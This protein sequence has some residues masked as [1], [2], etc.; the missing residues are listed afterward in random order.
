MPPP[1]EIADSLE[2]MT[3]DCDLI[4]L[5]H[6]YKLQPDV[7][8]VDDRTL[9]AQ[10]T[11]QVTRVLYGTFGADSLSFYWKADRVTPMDN[12]PQLYFLRRAANR[13]GEHHPAPWALRNSVLP[14]ASSQGLAT[15]TGGLAR[16]ADE[17][18]SVIESESAI[19]TANG[20]LIHIN[21][22]PDNFSRTKPYRRI[23]LIA[24][25]ERAR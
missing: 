16:T 12:R 24:L 15:A 10:A 25:R 3:W 4:V 2:W 17:I 19:R 8:A 11:I 6:P 22:G 1:I 14:S 21:P 7:T 23:V 20:S 5:G 9:E 13:E 18:M